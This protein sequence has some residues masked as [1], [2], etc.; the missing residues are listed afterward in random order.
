M[1]R[2]PGTN[3]FKEVNGTS[4]RGLDRPCSSERYV[5]WYPTAS[6]LE[7]YSDNGKCLNEGI[8]CCKKIAELRPRK[9]M[10][11]R[12]L[13]GC[14]F[15]FSTFGEKGAEV[16][17][18]KAIDEETLEKRAIHMPIFCNC[19]PFPVCVPCCS[20]KLKRRIGTNKFET[21]NEYGHSEGYC[22]TYDSS[23]FNIGLV[24]RG[25]NFGGDDRW[26]LLTMKIC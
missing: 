26:G 10:E 12:N 8:W 17:H 21:C 1:R 5:P 4:R 9:K 20:R 3:G 11:T 18:L 15:S 14:W 22:E 2:E 24:Q 23:R 13:N 7:T 25:L 16:Y 6:P 19:I